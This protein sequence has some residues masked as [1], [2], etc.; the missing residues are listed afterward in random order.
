M[1]SKLVTKRTMQRNTENSLKNPYIV[2][3]IVGLGPRV[4]IP[5]HNHQGYN[6]ELSRHSATWGGKRMTLSCCWMSHLAPVHKRSTVGLEVA[7]EEAGT[8]HTRTGGQTSRVVAAQG[9]SLGLLTIAFDSMIDLGTSLTLLIQRC[10]CYI[11]PVCP[12]TD[13]VTSP[14]FPN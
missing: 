8:A 3:F 14:C 7:A 4:W 5:K 9:A 12:S 2:W 10:H 11:S 1:I 6:I 13:R